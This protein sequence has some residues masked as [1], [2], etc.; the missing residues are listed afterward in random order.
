MIYRKIMLSSHE[1]AQN[2]AEL[3][4]ESIKLGV[5]VMVQSKLILRCTGN[6]V[7]ALSVGGTTAGYCRDRPA[8][9]GNR[10]VVSCW[11]GGSHYSSAFAK[12]LWKVVFITPLKRAI[13]NNLI[14]GPSLC[15]LVL[16]Q[17]FGLWSLRL[18][19]HVCPL[20]SKTAALTDDRISTMSEVISGIKTIKMN[21]WEKSFIDLIS[22]L[23]RKEISEILKSSYL[24]GMSLASFFA[25]SKIMIFVTF[26]TNDLL[27]NRITASQVFVVVMLFEALRFSSTLYF[28]MAVEN[29]SEAVVSIQRIENFLLLDEIPQLN[30]QLA[31]D[32]E[33]IVD[34]NNFTASWD[35]KSGTPTLQDLFFTARP[36]E[37]LAVVGPV[38]A[39]KSSLLRAV[40]GELPPSQGQVIVHGRI[41]YVPQQPWVFSGTVRSNILFGK[42]Y[43]EDRYEEVIKAC[44]LEE[45]LQ[46]LEDGDQTLIGDRGTPLSE[47]QKARVSLARAMYQDADIY[48]LDDP[49][50][51]VDAGVSRHL[52]EQCI[53]QALREKITILVTHQWQYLK[54]ASWILI[55]KGGTIVQRGTYIGLLKSGVDFDFLLKRNEQEPSPDLESSTLKNQSRP[56][57]R[58]AAPELQDTENIEVTLPLEDRLEGK[59]GIKTYNDYFTAGAQWLI[60][61][62]LILVNI[63]AQVAYVLQDWWLAYWANLQSTLYFGAYGKGETVVMLDLN[64]YLGTYSGL[65][66]STILFGI[67]RSLMLFYVLVNSSQTLHN[68][69][70]WSILRAPVLFFYRNPIGRI[71]NRFSK[72]IGHMDDLLPL[73]FQD[74]IQTF[75]L[76]VGVVGVMVAAIPWT[77]IPVIPLG[78]IFFVLRWYFLRTSRDV[79]RLECTTRSPVFSHLASS[80]R[81]LWNIR[82]YKAERRFQELFDTYQDLHSEP[83]NQDADILPPGW[84]P[85]SLLWNVGVSRGH[86]FEQCICQVLREKITILVT[87]QWQYLKA[88]SWILIL[89]G[90]GKDGCPFEIVSTCLQSTVATFAPTS[91]FLLHLT[92]VKWK[93]GTIVQRG[94]YIG[95]LKSGVDFDF[96]LKRNEQEPSPDLESSTLKNQSRPLMR[97][98]APELQDTENIE[99]TLP[100]EDRLEGKVGIKTY[101]DYFTAGAQWLI[102]IF[103]ILVNIA[104]QVAYVLQDWWLAYWANLQSTLYF[105]AY[106][107]GETVVM[108][109]LNWYL[110]TYSGLT[111]STILFGITRSLMLF[112]VLV[113]SSQTL[114]N[115]MLWSILRAPVL[116]FYRNPIGR[117]LNRFSKDIG[118]MDDLLPLIFQDF[119]QTFLLVVGVVGVMVAAIPW[120]AIPVIP[121]GIIFFVLRWYF[122]RTSRE[123]KRLECTTRSPVFSH[124][125]SS[126]RGLWTIRAYKAERRFQEL[127]DTYQDLHSDVICAISVTVVAFGALILVETL[128]PG[129]VGL[130]LSL[131]LTLTGMFQWC[132]RQSAEV[133]NM[134][135]SVERGIEYTDLEKEAPWEL[136]NRPPSSW[137]HGGEIDFYYINFRYS[138]DRPLVLKNLR[139]PTVPREK[140]GI[141]GRTGAGKSSLIAALFRLSEPEGG[142]WIDGIWTRDIGLHDLRKKMSVALQVQLKEAIKALPSGLCTE[143][144]ESGLNLSVGQRQLVC[145]ARAILRKNQ[146]LILDKATSNVDPSLPSLSSLKYINFSDFRTDELIEKKILEKFTQCTVLTITHRLSTIIDCERILVLDSGRRKEFTRPYDLLQN[147]DSLFYKMVQKLGKAEASALTERAKQELI[148]ARRMQP[149]SSEVKPNPLQDVNFHSCL[150][151][152]WINPFFLFGHK[153]RLKENEIHSVHPEDCSQHLGEEL[154]GYWKQEV[155]RAEKNGQKPSLKKA[156]IKCYWKSCLLSAIFIFFEA[157]R[158]S[159]SAMRK[160]TTGQIVNLLSNDVKRFD[161][162]FNYQ[163]PKG[164]INLNYV[165]IKPHSPSGICNRSK[166][167]ALTDNRIKTMSEVITGIRTIK[168][169]AWEKSFTD[170]ITRLRRNEISKILKSSYLRGTNLAIFF[171]ASKIMIFITFIIAVVLDNP[172]TASQVFLVV[173]LFETVRFTGTLYFPMA[174]EKVSEAVVSINRIKDFLLLEEILPHDHQLV[175]SDGETI[176]DVQDLTAFWD[177]ESGTPALQGLSFTVRRGELLA[178]VGPV[179]AGKSSLLSALLREMPLIQGNVNIHGRIAYV[180][181]QPWVFPGTVRSNILFGKKYEE[182]RYKEVIKAC[183]LEKHL[184]N[185]KEGDKTVIGDG[186]TPLS[187]GQKTRVSLARAV[188]QDADI[189]LLDDPLS[190]VDVEVSRHLFEQCICQALKDKI[191]ILVTHQ[192]QYLKAASEIVTLENGEMVQK[193]PYTEFLLKSG[194]DS[195]SLSKK[196]EESEPSFKSP[197]Q[198][199]ESS[200]LPVEDVAPEDHDTEDILVILPLEDYSKRQVGCKTCKNYFTAGAHWFIIIFLILMN[201][202]AQVAYVLQDWWLLDWANEHDINVSRQGNET[203]MIDLN[204]YLVVYSGRILNRFCKDIGRMDDLLP[205]TFQDLIQTFLLVIGVVIV[206]V[207]M[208]PWTAIPLALLGIIFFLLQLY[209]L[210]TSGNVKGLECAK[211]SPVFSHLASS[212]QGLRT[213]RAYKAEQK[214]QKLF[215]KCQDLHSESWFMLLTMSQCFAM[216]LDVVCAVLVIVVAVGALILQESWTPGQIGLV[217]S[218]TLTLMRMFQWCVRQSTEVENMMMSA[219]RVIEYTELEKEGPW[220]LDFRPP[221]YWPDSGIIAFNNVNFKYSPDG[222]LVLKDLTVST[223][224]K[225]KVCIVGKTGA[226]KSSLIAALFRFSDFQGTISID[227]NLTTSMGLYDLRKKMSVV[228]QEPVLFIGTMKENLDPFNDHK[229]EDLWNALEEVQ[230]KE[231]IQGLPGKMETELAESGSNLSVGQRQLL[232]LARALLRKNKIL[233]MDEAT[234]NVDPRTDELIRKIIHGT[235]V[236]CTVVTITNRLSSVV[237]SDRIMVLD[238]GK[239][240]EYDKPHV[241]LH[242]K[243]SLFYKM[244][245]HL[246]ETEANALIEKA[247]Q[248]HFKRK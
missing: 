233:I 30:P 239:L 246:G 167:A 66:V 123:V 242:N 154:Q 185:L 83:C 74:F 176:V 79:K 220:E 181:Q 125:A 80:L 141:V 118:H 134:M 221:V 162:C 52:F 18:I 96:L 34:M 24:R 41:A 16:P 205:L 197:D 173:M 120:T 172:I 72:D 33:T 143:L 55:L 175:P 44:A 89:K 198:P 232:C 88:A 188:Y 124:L 110:G 128:T 228:P 46:F 169:Y 203:K 179:G 61:I 183:A 8:L 158:L 122:L 147:T 104:A 199:Q 28:P 211:Q 224:S 160:T 194:I 153:W 130:V 78:I 170:F 64:W 70:L 159:N 126:L 103:L 132:V 238:S 62:F 121:L 140:L 186:G 146:I 127:F 148:Q 209:F 174:I 90:K 200:T 10:N 111:V 137:P 39:G 12:L 129:Q 240:E 38:G 247:K 25:V 133:E 116:F 4:C 244:V 157:L 45:D 241:L 50:S 67:T 227:K 27:D 225:E 161:Q 164:K 36:G 212:L 6:D 112:Y 48:L 243:N 54:A 144:A 135:I 77:A 99:V 91:R 168:M 163:C 57:M 17:K 59:V 13:E 139:V 192:L 208:I 171:A 106:G 231:T 3:Y 73:I 219:E 236:Q 215:E 113:N 152:L 29:V 95:L 207:A 69:M 47:G 131:T 195:G 108:L 100:L 196:T 82:A 213:I 180:S 187:E 9:D 210:N 222:P 190:A 31:S 71:L 151:F 235:F 248:A 150:F 65:T 145:L 60:L 114:H 105:G 15:P 42:K 7:L 202:A 156:I 119:I 98:A 22:R 226:G 102:L 43:E 84:D 85:F 37:L 206:M 58:G 1:Y 101:N 177:K 178:V 93:M 53:C 19:S 201:I 166:T 81:G 184:Q 76:V 94:T 32:G 218:L 51:A 21:A 191:T 245:Q 223:E 217:L 117:I 68:K 115:K 165:F 56:L 155:E 214:F 182:D 2:S 229:E 92:D 20:R 142:V 109:D 97:G 149:V 193:G 63:A 234:S 49:F 216:C 14:P 26:I 5:K 204:W 136:E 138:L 40:L 230:L 87:H 237:D 107:K 189:Y 75:L 86:L 35:K 23:R 11:N